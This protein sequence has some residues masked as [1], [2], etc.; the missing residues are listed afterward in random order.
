L[1]PSP[2]R[3]RTALFVS[4]IDAIGFLRAVWS[5]PFRTGLTVPDY[6]IVGEEYGDSKSGWTAGNGAPF[7]GGGTK[8]AGG[9]LAAGYWSNLWEYDSECGYLT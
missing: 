9:I 5:I 6:M 3:T 1:A 7:S 8:G 4:G 2:A